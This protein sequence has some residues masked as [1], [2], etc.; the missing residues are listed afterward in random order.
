MFRTIRPRDLALHAH[1]HG[2]GP[3]FIARSFPTVFL[4]F[5]S[6]NALPRQLGPGREALATTN[7]DFLVCVFSHGMF[8]TSG[9][10]GAV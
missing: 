2:D 1:L 8:I 9:S 7:A 5:L 4:R 3:I 6:G 10:T